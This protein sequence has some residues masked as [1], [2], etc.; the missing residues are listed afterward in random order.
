MRLLQI[1]NFK[2]KLLSIY[3]EAKNININIHSRERER[4]REHYIPHTKKKKH[5]YI[6]MRIHIYLIV[7]FMCFLETFCFVLFC[8]VLFVFFI[9]KYPIYIYI[10][11]YIQNN[12]V[13]EISGAHRKNCRAL[14]HIIGYFHPYKQHTQTYIY[15][16]I[17][18]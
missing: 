9:P 2:K 5:I 15:R 12:N 10:Y 7:C 13:R 6:F 3:M 1:N 8:F 17:Y 16:Y 14:L 18:I 4:E 11:I